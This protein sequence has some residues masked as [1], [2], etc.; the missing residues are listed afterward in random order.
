MDLAQLLTPQN[1]GS[2]LW[3]GAPGPAMGPRLFGGQAIA[4]ALMA[5][6]GEESSDRR[7]HSLH[8]YFLKAGSSSEAV[9]YSVATLSEG[10]SFATRRVEA[11]QGEALIFSMIASFHVPEPGF[12]HKVEPPFELDVD[13]AVAKL[14]E[15]QAG[16]SDPAGF[17]IL[18]RLKQRPIEIVHLDPGALFE[19]RPRKPQ[20]GM[21]MRM[22]E[23]AEADPDVQR[24]LL[25]Y[26]SDMMFLRNSM[27]PHGI[28]PWS[29][30]VQAASLDHAIWFHETP[31]LNDWHL[32]ATGSP[33][34]GHARGLNQGHFFRQDGTM[35]ATV[36]QENLMRPVGEALERATKEA[37]QA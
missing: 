12:A 30:K 24:A 14:E 25:S 4:Q 1:C 26:A 8:C 21:W 11:R 18:D 35:V 15:W 34:A 32:F 3:R 37:P 13:A 10:R 2:G 9:D 6:S 36:T 31:N 20:T 28:R 7:A 17:P 33:W 19:P 23:P 22:R 29:G 5:A 27:L 16:N